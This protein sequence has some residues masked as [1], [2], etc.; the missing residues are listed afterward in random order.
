MQDIRDISR[1]KKQILENYNKSIIIIFIILVL[2][3]I[4][5]AFFSVNFWLDTI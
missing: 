4:L 1:T 5:V 3:A 2:G